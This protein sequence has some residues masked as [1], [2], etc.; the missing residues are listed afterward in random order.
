VLRKQGKGECRVM[1]R[2]LGADAPA[3]GFD[4]DQH[5]LDRGVILG[6]DIRRGKLL[7][8]HAGGLF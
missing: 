6:F 2:G 5:E 4:I 8:A 1:R 3:L 7:E